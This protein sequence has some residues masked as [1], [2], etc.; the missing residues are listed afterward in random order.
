MR[1]FVVPG[2]LEDV[3]DLFTPDVRA[4]MRPAAL[5]VVTFAGRQYGVPYQHYQVGLYL[6]RDLL[7]AAHVGGA[8]GT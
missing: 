7:A 5:D 1:Q 4:T 6:R 2:L 3:S 8:P